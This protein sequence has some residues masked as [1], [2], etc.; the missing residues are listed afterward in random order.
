[1]AEH[2]VSAVALAVL[3]GREYS[4]HPASEHLIR[5]SDSLEPA[6][7]RIGS[8]IQRRIVSALQRH[9]G[10]AKL[11]QCRDMAWSRRIGKHHSV[12]PI[13]FASCRAPAQP[14]YSSMR[15]IG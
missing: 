15:T 1:M 4:D 3:A 11:Q 10:I 13:G 9:S 6:F 2:L 12:Q 5:V 14:A 7:R 8:T